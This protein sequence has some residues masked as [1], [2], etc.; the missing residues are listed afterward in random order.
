MVSILLP[1]KNT[2][3]FLIDCLD[4][5]ANQ[6]MAEWECIAIDDNS[7][8][9]SSAILEQYSRM[10]S[11]FRV[12][13][14]VGQGIISALRMALGKSQGAFITRMDSDDIMSEDKLESMMSVITGRGEIAV[15]LVKYFP[16]DYVQGGY[17]K[18]AKWLNE[19]TLSENNFEE[20]Y[21]ECVIPSPCWMMR[22][23]DLDLCGAFDNDVY[24]EDYD[25]CHRMRR[26]GY[27]VKGVNKII[28]YWR[29]Y[30][31]RTSR[32]DLHYADNRF[33]DLKVHYFVEVDYVASDSLILWG[34]GKKGKEISKR[35]IERNIPFTWVCNNAKKIGKSIYGRM[36]YDSE[37]INPNAPLQVIIAVANEDEQNEIKQR[38][39]TFPKSKAYWFC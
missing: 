14:N 29:D 38:I 5:I 35:L 11:R 23:E 7:T 21:K 36:M 1:V 9:E 31:T 33:L 17:K 30:P 13:R 25:L 37:E 27:K 19:L 22:R 26:A 4:S 10:D 24:P 34:A 32:T 15:G 6:T 18:Y 8:D 39:C 20:V 28:H 2:A 16:E 3:R 12:Y